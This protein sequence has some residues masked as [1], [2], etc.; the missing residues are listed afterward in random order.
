MDLFPDFEYV[1]ITNSYKHNN[2]EIIMIPKNNMADF[3][4]II[5]FNFLKFI[6]N[7]WD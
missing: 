3:Y 7:D 6:I 5:V 2:V 1:T 4:N